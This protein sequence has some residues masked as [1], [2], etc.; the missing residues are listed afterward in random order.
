MS[1]IGGGEREYKVTK[2]DHAYEMVYLFHRRTWR[3]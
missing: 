1:T 3:V 2:E